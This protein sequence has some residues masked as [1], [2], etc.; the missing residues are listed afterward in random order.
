VI[1]HLNQEEPMRLDVLTLAALVAALA[2]S[3]AAAAAPPPGKGRDHGVANATQARANADQARSA[4]RPGGCR[5]VVSLILRGLYVSGSANAA[6]VGEFV[7]EVERSNKHARFFKGKPTTLK[8]DARTKVRR[9]GK[10]SP[11]DLQPGDRVNAHARACR[12]ADPATL[13]LLARKV[14]ARPATS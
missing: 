8:T 7:L 12:T 11:A 4:R 14:V 2:V 6:G 5:P 9:E 13:E 10:A 1:A 3:A